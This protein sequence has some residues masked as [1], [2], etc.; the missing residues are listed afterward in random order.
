[1]TTVIIEAPSRNHIR[2][3]T[4]GWINPIDPDPDAILIEDIAHALSNQCRF[5]GHVT[6]FYSVA[7]HSCRVADYLLETDYAFEGLMHDAS[8]AYISDLARP[9][10]RNPLIAEVYNEA[11]NRLMSAIAEKFGFQFPMSDPVKYADD[12]LLR[13]EQR[14]LMHGTTYEGELLEGTIKPWIPDY[15]K[16]TF[17]TMYRE[18]KR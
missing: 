8:E 5:T 10:K 14:D 6:K 2:T 9:V 12:V 1:M 17:Y 18:L 4:G 3:Y 16:D 7:E 15:A 13:T 11:E